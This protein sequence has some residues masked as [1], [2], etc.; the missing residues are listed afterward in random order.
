MFTASSILKNNNIIKTLIL[1]LILLTININ[2]FAAQSNTETQS[3]TS[4]QTS[5]NRNTQAQ[6]GQTASSSESSSQTS[7]N[8]ASSSNPQAA[9]IPRAGQRVQPG[10]SRRRP[11]RSRTPGR[12]PKKKNKYFE[13]LVGPEASTC[14]Y[15]ISPVSDKSIPETNEFTF[16]GGAFCDIRFNKR[17]GLKVSYAF[18][19]GYRNINVFSC[20]GRYNLALKHQLWLGM[21]FALHIAD[22]FSTTEN[23]Q[24]AV[25]AG[26]LT[27]INAGTEKRLLL[28][29]VIAMGYYLEVSK[30]IV[31]DFE[32][33]YC[34]F[35]HKAKTWQYNILRIKFGVGFRL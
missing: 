34:P 3:S 8:P 2:V 15:F 18:Q 32:I 4:V 5:E 11:T 26:L 1:V 29:Y 20:I 30:L 10:T 24:S 17:F 16:A 28:F 9:P 27:D 35:N 14:M 12:R 23:N 22:F 6:E 7:S 33:S 31:L 19:F 13:I 25:T 21:G